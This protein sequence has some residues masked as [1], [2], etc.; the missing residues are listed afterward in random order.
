MTLQKSSN[1][2]EWPNDKLN[3]LFCKALHNWKDVEEHF[4]DKKCIVP[5]ANPQ[6]HL[7]FASINDQIKITVLYYAVRGSNIVENFNVWEKMVVDFFEDFLW[8][9]ILTKCCTFISNLLLRICQKV[10]VTVADLQTAPL[11]LGFVILQLLINAATVKPIIKW[12]NYWQYY[13]C[14]L[15]WFAWVKHQIRTSHYLL[16]LPLHLLTQATWQFAVNKTSVQSNWLFTETGTKKKFWFS[17]N[18]QCYQSLKLI[19]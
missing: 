3:L 10:A 17:I 18:K 13:F 7:N 12:E 5:Q 1:K 9:S 8:I 6:S 11:N 2:S 15:T 16:I 14:F 4:C 19:P